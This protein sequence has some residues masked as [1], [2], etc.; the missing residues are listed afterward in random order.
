MT[1]NSVSAD[2]ALASLSLSGVDI[3]AFSSAVTDYSASVANS[4]MATT[5]AASATHPAATVSIH[6]GASVTLAEGANEIV[7]TVTAEAAGRTPTR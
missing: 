4:V 1:I 6:P 7:I 3:G 5:V 2:A